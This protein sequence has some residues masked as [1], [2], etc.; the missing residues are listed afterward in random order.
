MRELTCSEVR[1]WDASAIAQVFQV[2]KNR[3]GT[4]KEFGDTIGSAQQELNDWGGEAGD[5]FHQ[6]AQHKRQYLDNDQLAPQLQAA[7]ERA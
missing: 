5:S 3:D 1:R 6:E 7:V 2:V 4:V